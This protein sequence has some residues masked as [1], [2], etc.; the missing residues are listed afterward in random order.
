MNWRKALWTIPV[1]LA[2]GAMAQ[3]GPIGDVQAMYNAQAASGNNWNF[4]GAFNGALTGTAVGVQDGVVFRIDNLSA[5]TL[6]NVTL[7][8][9]VGGDNA[10]AD[11]FAVGSIAAGSYVVVAPGLSN[12][13]GA[14]HTFFAHTGGIRDESDVG[15][16]GNGVPFSVTAQQGL[17]LP[18]TGTFTPDATKGQST[19][20]TIAVINFLGGPDDGA[21]ND[22][23]GP[24]V[25]A[26]LDVAAVP[27]P[28]SLVLLSCG[29]FCMA[30][31]WCWRKKRQALKLASR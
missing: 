14:G 13:G 19:D 20:H 5:T 3:A 8:I 16:D 24:Q 10:T 26:L 7:N 12:D 11:S 31:G 2:L 30:T 28:S 15:P 4:N 22:C 18:T 25:V 17:L 23:F 1:W 29:G 6:T 9:G 27:E 21:C